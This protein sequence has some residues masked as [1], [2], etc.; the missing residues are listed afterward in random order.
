MKWLILFGLKILSSLVL[1]FWLSSCAPIMIEQVSA[2]KEEFIN[3]E[4]IDRRIGVLIGRG[5]TYKEI[6]IYYWDINKN[7][8]IWLADKLIEPAWL[9]NHFEYYGGQAYRVQ[10]D[11]LKLPYYGS[12]KF[13]VYPYYYRWFRKVYMDPV[14]YYLTITPDSQLKSYGGAY[15][16]WLLE[17]Y[18]DRPYESGGLRL[19]I[20]IP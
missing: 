2:S 6:K 19:E 1:L 18:I 7:E 13:V 14:Y 11:I 16:G 10:I 20:N 17:I 4:K 5:N 12:Y 9:G 15:V 8:W 3:H